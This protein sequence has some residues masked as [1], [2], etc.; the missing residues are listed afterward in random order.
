MI[1][2]EFK[3]EDEIVSEWINDVNIRIEA[4]K[5]FKK[6][7]KNKSMKQFENEYLNHF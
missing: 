3:E 7:K 1:K 5:M 2:K 6:L 4:S